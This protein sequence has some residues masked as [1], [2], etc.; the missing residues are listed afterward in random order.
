MDNLLYLSAVKISSMIRSRKITSRE[1]V[2]EQ[3]G[4]IEKVN[5]RLN[6]I[7]K[8]NGRALE[9]AE[10]YDDYLNKGKCLGPLHGVPV[11]IKDSFDTKDLTTT[12]GTLGRKDYIP[13]IDAAVVEKLKKAGAIILGKT[14]T[15]ELTLIFETDNLLYGKTNNPYDI[16][17]TPGGSSGGEAAMI[18]SGV[19]Y[20]GI[21]SDTGGSIRLPAHFCG[22]AGLKPTMGRVS[23]YG[24]I[25]SYGGI[26]D[27]LTQIGPMARYVEDLALAYNIIQGYDYRD[28]STV[29]AEVKKFQDVDLSSLKV[30]YFEDNGIMTPTGDV[31]KTVRDVAA[32]I[33]GRVKVI[34]ED[35][36]QDIDSIDKL[37]GKIFS[38]D[39][40]KWIREIINK[41]KTYEIHSSLKW[42]FNCEGKPEMTVCEF[43]ELIKNWDE[44]KISMEEFF[45]KYDVLICPVNA[46][47]A[48]KHGE[49]LSRENRKAFSYT[50]IFNLTG[51]PSAVVRAGFSKEG[52]PIG[53]QIVSKKWREDICLKVAQDIEKNFGG[54]IKPNI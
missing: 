9:Q 1:I 8:I 43:A 26:L 29:D 24:H 10:E 21:G 23:R 37:Y 49:T 4:R 12:Y 47:P 32:Y 2:N 45:N 30:A 17:R 50:K 31:V 54:W 7:V 3:L 15:P 36:P 35:K 11:T 14:N 46:K 27:A 33:K 6:G 48:M 13:G 5:P 34:E 52:L 41:C 53:V 40:G 22:I 18:A 16:C 38:A 28:P 20:I 25:I 51:N 42:A 19:S 39:G 44:L